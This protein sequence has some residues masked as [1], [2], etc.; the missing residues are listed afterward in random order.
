V[1]LTGKLKIANDESELQKV[2]EEQ[3]PK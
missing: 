2:N 1:R 3:F